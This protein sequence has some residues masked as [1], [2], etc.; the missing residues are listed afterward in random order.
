MRKTAL[1]VLLLAG[2]AL[3]QKAPATGHDL[4]QTMRDA[5][6]SHWFKTLTFVQT[7]TR[8]DSTG[9]EV[10]T[11]WYE[12]LRYTD[13]T[14]TQLRIDIGDPK[15]GNG[16]IYTVDSLWGFRGGK[17]AGSRAAGNLLL[18]LVEGI[19]VEPVERTLRELAPT[20]VDFTKPVLSGSWHGRPVWIAGAQAA[21]DT[22]SPQ[23]WVDAQ[24][25]A[26][27]RAVFSPVAGAPV[28]DMHFEK[29]VQAGGGALATRCEFYVA[30]KLEQAEDYNDW[31]T[32]VD[33]SPGLF[34]PATFST[35]PHWVKS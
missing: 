5:Y 16:V 30:G 11:T 34:D 12:S 10:K 26:V 24:N 28:M 7:T 1:C 32:D 35:A 33:L 31:K 29:V 25:K 20:G 17:L 22:T 14:G 27:V 9:K 23:I 15:N 3:A 6:G 19:Y 13:A 8:H 2:P 21:G 4:L 18:P